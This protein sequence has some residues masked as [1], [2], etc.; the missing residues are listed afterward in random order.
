MSLR[1]L[2]AGSVLLVVVGGFVAV[3]SSLHPDA[4]RRDAEARLSS[5][6]GQPV[7]IGSMDVSMFPVPAVIGSEI[8]VGP[9]RERPELALHRIRLV[10]RIASLF[11]GPYVIREVVLEGLA[12]R[13]VR[14]RGRWRFPSV[15]PVP[16][17]D[18]GSGLVIERVSLSDGV[19]RVFELAD[20]GPEQMT[21]RIDGI[22]GTAVVGADGLRVAPIRGRVGGSEIT[23]E[24]VLNAQEAR[25]NLAMAGAGGED[26]DDLLGLA[27]IAPPEFVTLHKPAAVSIAIRID[28]TRSQLSGA[29]TLR[30]PEVGFHS[31]RLHG[32][33]APIKTDGADLTFEPATFT[34]YGGRHRGAMSVDLIRSRWALESKITDLDVGD[35]LS[36]MTG[37][38]QRIDGTGSAATAL[39]GRIGDPM[40]Q[41]LEGRMTVNVVNGVIRE[42]PLLSAIN[43]ALRLAEGD[44]RDTRFERLSATLAFAGNVR[45]SAGAPGAGHAT[46]DDLVME[47][48]EVR[49]EAAGR[50][51]FDRSLDLTGVAVLSPERTASAVRSVRELSGLRNSQGE[52]ELP[53]TITG[54]LD[55]PS[56]GI[57][58]KAVIARSIKE[59]L[60]RGIRRL[61]RR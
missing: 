56:F 49:V 6:L 60:R 42:F 33:E 57:D 7:A 31:L 47:A 61:F 21:S 51:G 2:I 36:A 25:M 32:L 30:A 11:S 9:D 20:R 5:M 26:L 50:I 48:R 34:M 54:T 4:I 46:T 45:S 10:P 44:A 52:L 1:R 38:G 53:L 13:V 12:V 59:E 22:D 28:R 35:F 41:G 3:R 37:G 58:L 55:H 43:R 18:P 17:G 40:P 27:T 19:V 24:A 23:G 15:M 29:G 16:G 8:V 39:R 14:E